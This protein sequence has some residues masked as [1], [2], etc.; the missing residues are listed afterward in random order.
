MVGKADP[1]VVIRR[2]RR[3]EENNGGCP[4][5]FLGAANEFAADPTALVRNP[6]GEVRKVGAV[7]EIAQASGNPN[8]AFAIPG[9]HDKVGAGEHGP[10]PLPVMD[11]PA[12]AECGRLV[13]FND[14]VEV[15]IVANAIGN[16]RTAV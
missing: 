14:G 11:R 7:A 1:R 5:Q 12:F 13:K 2:F 16:H 10:N 8:Q 15:E 3:G 6:D 9:A 4:T